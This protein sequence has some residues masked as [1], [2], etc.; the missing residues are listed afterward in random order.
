MKTILVIDDEAPILKL[1]NTI[2]TREGFRV[3]TAG[4]GNEAIRIVDDEPV[5]LV[6]TDIVM[7]EKEGLETIYELRKIDRNLP[8][9]AMS[10]GGKNPAERYLQT[11]KMMGASATLQ[12]PISKEELLDVVNRAIIGTDS[13]E[14]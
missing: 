8:V 12:K 9:I 7:P 10:G 4:D 2:L 3:L 13:L 6:I 11:A 1:L 14:T 5:D